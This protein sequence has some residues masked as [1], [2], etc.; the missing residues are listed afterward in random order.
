MDLR[1]Q[2]RCRSECGSH[3]GSFEVAY[4]TVQGQRWV[5]ESI[6]EQY[7]LVIVI[8]G[9]GIS[10]LATAHIYHPDVDVTYVGDEEARTVTA[11]KFV[12]FVEVIPGLIA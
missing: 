2:R 11:K 9:A 12:N 8:V 4:A 1:D 10:D 5:G 6:D 7:D 3:P